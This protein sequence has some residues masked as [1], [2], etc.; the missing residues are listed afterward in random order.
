MNKNKKDLPIVPDL[1]TPV[2]QNVGDF[3]YEIAMVIDD[4]IYDI[5]NVDGQQAAQYMAQPKFVL[6][7]P[8]EAKIG[9]IYKDGEISYPEI[10]DLGV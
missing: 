10:N 3:P 6:F 9:W 1:E 7:N 4:I 5:Y 2:P 8:G